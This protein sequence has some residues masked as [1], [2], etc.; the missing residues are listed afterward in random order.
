MALRDRVWFGSDIGGIN[1]AHWHNWKPLNLSI[2]KLKRTKLKL[3]RD[4]KLIE[5][6]VF[7]ESYAIS[8]TVI[9]KANIL[10]IIT[11]HIYTTHTLWVSL[12]SHTNVYH[13]CILNNKLHNLVLTL[14]SKNDQRFHCDWKSVSV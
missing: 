4:D 13:N 2:N 1:R 5:K 3:H 11:E 12:M 7:W 14:V 6:I 10:L 9:I 8:I